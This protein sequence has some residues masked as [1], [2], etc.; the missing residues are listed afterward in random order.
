MIPKKAVEAI[1]AAICEESLEDHMD[2]VWPG[3]CVKAAAAP[4]LLGSGRLVSTYYRSLTLD[5]S[6]W[7]ESHNPDEVRKMSEG[8]DCIFEVIHHY[9][10]TDGW[11]K[12]TTK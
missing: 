11:Q 10:Q 1:H 4:H 8:V 12:W 3:R 5:G 2:P 7:C 9:E 6:V